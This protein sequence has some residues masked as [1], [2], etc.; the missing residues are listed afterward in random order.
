MSLRPKSKCASTSNKVNIVKPSA[1][2]SIQYYFKLKYLFTTNN[3]VLQ[4]DRYY[5]ALTDRID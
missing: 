1:Y 3:N 5:H 2:V 4:F